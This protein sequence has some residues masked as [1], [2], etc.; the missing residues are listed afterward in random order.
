M[1]Q[2]PSL[3]LTGSSVQSSPIAGRELRLSE[4]PNALPTSDD[5]VLIQDSTSNPVAVHVSGLGMYYVSLSQPE[6]RR[7]LHVPSPRMATT[8]VFAGG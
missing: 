1:L 7:Q 4:C 6:K 2:S 8:S 3:D 5:V